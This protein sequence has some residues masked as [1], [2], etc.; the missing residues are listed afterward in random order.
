MTV[1]VPVDNGDG[2]G[3]V[4]FGMAEHHTSAWE[5]AWEACLN[6]LTPLRSQPCSPL[7]S[8]RG[9]RSQ[10]ARLGGTPRRD[11]EVR[12]DAGGGGRAKGL[13]ISYTLRRLRRIQL[14]LASVAVVLLTLASPSVLTATA[15]ACPDLAHAPSSRWQITVDQGVA[16]LVTPCGDR[17]FSLGVN[18]VDGGVESERPSYNWDR[19]YPDLT[20]LLGGGAREADRLGI[21]H[22]R[23]HTRSRPNS[24]NSPSRSDTELGLNRRLSLDRPVPP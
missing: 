1:I 19:Y 13:C 24:S 17:F 15:S 7:H 11:S 8:L 3:H 12:G 10:P 20:G 2:Q 5:F 14:V 9:L 16:W 21:Q 23:W 4:P 6:V 18:V 22:T